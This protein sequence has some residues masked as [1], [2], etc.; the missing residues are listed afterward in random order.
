[1]CDIMVWSSSSR[2]DGCERCLQLLLRSI[3]CLEHL[4]VCVRTVS[5][6]ERRGIPVF[7][8]SQ[9]D[10][11]NTGTWRLIITVRIPQEGRNSSSHSRF[12]V[13]WAQ[14]IMPTL[15]WTIIK[16]CPSQWLRGLSFSSMEAHPT[17]AMVVNLGDVSLLGRLSM[18]ELYTEW[19]A[20]NYCRRSSHSKRRQ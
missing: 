18:P 4:H 15:S 10:Q 8:F 19:I 9:L 5:L 17:V 7:N 16:N 6:P 14:M 13:T 20:P 11:E 1:M 2:Y 3:Q 12:V